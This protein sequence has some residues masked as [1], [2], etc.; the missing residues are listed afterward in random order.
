MY[1][2]LLQAVIV[3]SCLDIH[4]FIQSDGAVLI[5]S[6]DLTAGTREKEKEEDKVR[7]ERKAEMQV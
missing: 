3:R 7:E 2:Y 6:D 4:F 1:S 5:L